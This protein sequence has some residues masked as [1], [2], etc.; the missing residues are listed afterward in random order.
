MWNIYRDAL[1]A[2]VMSDSERIGGEATSAIG[3]NA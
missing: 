3:T 1:T 2:N